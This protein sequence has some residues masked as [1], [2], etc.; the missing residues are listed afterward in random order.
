MLQFQT[1][2]LMHAASA[3]QLDVVEYLVEE[4]EADV[5]AR[6]EVRQPTESNMLL[7]WFGG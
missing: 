5:N 4:C 2:P 6:D 7:V 3:G 1:T